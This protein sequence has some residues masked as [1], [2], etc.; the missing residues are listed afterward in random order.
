[1]AVV[2]N[3]LLRGGKSITR[4][5]EKGGPENLDFFWPASA[6]LGP[7]TLIGREDD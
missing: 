7:K 2:L 3:V 4:D 5:I 6:I 1:M